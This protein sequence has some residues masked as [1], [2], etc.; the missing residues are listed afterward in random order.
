M[1][2]HEVLERYSEMIKDTTY[3]LQ[4][5]LQRVDEKLASI[6]ADSTDNPGTNVD[7]QD[8]RE[9]TR[10]CLRICQDA[11]SYLENLQDRQ[12][13]SPQVAAPRNAGTVRNLFDAEVMTRQTL[14]ES[15][16]RIVATMG[17][18]QGRLD[19]LISSEGSEHES[20]RSRLQEDIYISKQCLEV[21]KAA[22]DR[23]SYQKIHIIG[24]VRADDDTDQV[25]ITT[26]ADLFDVGKVLA[27]SRSAQ[28]V[29]SMSDESLQKVSADR[30]NSRFG[31]ITGDPGRGPVGIGVPASGLESRDDTTQPPVSTKKDG[32]QGIAET[33]RN[34]P[35]PNEVRKRA[36]EGE[37]HT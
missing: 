24:E 2:S 8:E 5:H 11:M 22:S 25:V 13:S 32:K 16:D 9:V 33:K 26:L 7:L 27:K 36:A 17:R 37:G 21:C 3:N 12:P 20:Q 4:I 35:S 15:R 10:Q 31:A 19:S 30:Y 14:N 29:G 18:L 34:R 1:L 23:V 28:L 6:A